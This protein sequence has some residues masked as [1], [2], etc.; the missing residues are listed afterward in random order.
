MVACCPFFPSGRIASWKESEKRVLYSWRAGMVVVWGK[1]GIGKIDLETDRDSFPA[2][3]LCH[4][5]MIDFTLP[6]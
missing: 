6:Y 2:K 4:C 1:V 5:D 3:G